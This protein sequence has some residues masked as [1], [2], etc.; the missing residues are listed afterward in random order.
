MQPPNPTGVSL[1]SSK[2]P[3]EYRVCVADTPEQ[4]AGQ[5]TEQL[6]QGWHLHGYPF[7]D[8]Q[9]QSN[10]NGR[11]LS[12]NLF[13]QAMVRTPIAAPVAKATVRATPAVR[14]ERPKVPATFRGVATFLAVLV[15]G[16]LIAEFLFFR[17]GFYTRYL[18]PE[19]STGSFEG[20]F[21]LEKNRAPTHK[22]EVL[23][24]GSSRLAEGF[25]AK[26]SDRYKPE[27]GYRF[28][29]CAVPSSG[30]RTF[31][32]QIR[33][34][35]PQRNRYAAIAIP[36]DDFNDL[37]DIEDVAD[38]VSDIRLEINRLRVTDIVPYTLSFTRWKSRREILRGVLFKGTVYQL[39]LADFIEHPT[40]RLARVKMFRENAG[41]WGYDYGGIERNLAGLNVDWTTRHA[42]YPPG[43]PE[44]QRRFLE[45]VFFEKH[46]Q[47]GRNRDFEVRWLGLLVDRYRDSK[48]KIIIF[49]PPRGPFPRPSPNLPWTAV[50]ELRKR[51]WVTIIDSHKFESLEKPELFAD[52]VHLNSEG[53]KIFTPMFVDAV[54]EVVH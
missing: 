33:D 45:N 6:S 48:T 28:F 40:E 17:S 8:L 41:G 12:G 3:T 22:K 11:Q 43:M 46:L 16:Y 1:D 49:Q 4:L 13:C 15:C 18:E 53:R 23:V 54:K 21:R 24:V 2:S 52:H 25:S 42:T 14:P 36:I 10:G 38:R 39:D 26:L 7:V 35:D 44:D 50:D 37:D 29:N 32:Y 19:S 34:L 5:V 30:A 51:S 20:T 27:D 9:F 47:R 31:Y